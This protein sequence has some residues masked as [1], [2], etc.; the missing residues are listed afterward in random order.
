MP[1][2]PVDVKMESLNTIGRHQK[3]LE[4]TR[5]FAGTLTGPYSVF[6]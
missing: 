1:A 4:N 6:S 3:A 5:R 2:A